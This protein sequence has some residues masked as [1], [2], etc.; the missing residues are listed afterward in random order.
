MFLLMH[1]L[2]AIL[3]QRPLI[4]NNIDVEKNTEED[5]YKAV[6]VEDYGFYFKENVSVTITAKDEVKDYDDTQKVPLYK[7]KDGIVFKVNV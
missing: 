5:I 2:M 7:S 1:R 3:T 4:S 6:T